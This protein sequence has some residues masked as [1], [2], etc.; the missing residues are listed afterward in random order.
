MSSARA[1]TARIGSICF[2]TGSRAGQRNPALVFFKCLFCVTISSAD[3]RRLLIVCF[4]CVSALS[5]V[6][7][8]ELKSTTSTGSSQ[9]RPCS[10]SVQFRRCDVN[11]PLGL[12]FQ[13]HAENVLCEVGRKTATQSIFVIISGRY[14]QRLFCNMQLTVDCVDKEIEH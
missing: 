4:Y 12:V 10:E 13:H 14:W 2:Q 6:A 8:I 3:C 7:T 11:R 9:F 1:E 5:H